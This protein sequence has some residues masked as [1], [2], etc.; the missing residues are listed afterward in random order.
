MGDRVL[1][2]KATN[3]Y[4]TMY[5]FA[6]YD[7]TLHASYIQ[8][9]SHGVI[10]DHMIFVGGKA[11]AAS[12][13]RVRDVVDGSRAHITSILTVD[14][15]GAFAPFTA[16]GTIVINGGVLASGY[17]NMQSN[18]QRSELWIGDLDTGLSMQFVSHL[19]LT[20]VR[21]W[22]TLDTRSAVHTGPGISSWLYLPHAVLSATSTS[23]TSRGSFAIV[24]RS[25]DLWIG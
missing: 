23:G 7:E 21:L 6:R 8:L 10:E 11:I 13:V 9:L 19:A 25:A 2:D 22:C 24:S 1:V 3:R 18:K 12:A 5:H 20:S 16:S 14:R 4:E 15:Q 17:V